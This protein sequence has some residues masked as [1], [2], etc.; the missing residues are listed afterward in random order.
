MTEQTTAR[1]ELTKR[2]ASELG[3]SDAY[4]QT[5]KDSYAKNATDAELAL[6]LQVANRTGLDPTARQIY[7]VKRWDSV[8][9]REVAQPQTSIDGLRLIADRTGAYVPGREPLFEHDGD[10]NLVSA[11]AFVKKLVAGE[12]HEIAATARWDEYCQRTKEGKLSAMWAKMPY[13]ML[14]KCAEALALRK[15]FPAQ[16]SGLYTAE[17]MGQAEN[18]VPEKAGGK[19]RV[20]ANWD[21]VKETQPTAAASGDGEHGPEAGQEDEKR[22]LIGRLKSLSA[23]INRY[24]SDDRLKFTPS[25]LAEFISHAS[26]EELE[27]IENYSTSALR[28]ALGQLEAM[29]AK[30][31]GEDGED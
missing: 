3:I 13:L 31:A 4:L 22:Q 24:R 20:M 19:V 1:Q 6:F 23:E 28:L 14:A 16:L 21:A 9:K 10:G 8:L 25:L 18:P 17:E 29:L 30:E 15:A 12:W 2:I 7:L 27:A 11:T 5:I 26:G